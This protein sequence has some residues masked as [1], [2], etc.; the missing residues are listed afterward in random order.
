[1]PGRN[2]AVLAAVRCNRAASAGVEVGMPLAEAVSRLHDPYVVPLD[3]ER[4]RE[5]LTV[6]AADCLRYTPCVGLDDDDRPDGLLLDVTGCGHLFGGEG[7]LARRAVLDLRRGGLA[8]RGGVAGT[9]GLA[10]AAARFGDPSEPATTVSDGDRDRWLAGRPLDALR[11]DDGTV[12]KLNEFGIDTVGAL[13]GLPRRSLPSRFG[14][15]LTRRLDQ[16]CGSVPEAIRPVYP[17]EP[18]RAVRRFD[19]PV[20]GGLPD[21]LVVTLTDALITAV[22]TAFGALAIGW[23]IEAGDGEGDDAVFDVRFASP[24]REV[25]KIAALTRLR[26]ERSKLPGRYE[27]V[28]AEVLKAETIVGRQSD[29]F[30]DRTADRRRE[31]D[32]LIERLTSRLGRDRVLRP[33]LTGDPVPERS[34]TFSPAIDPTRDRSSGSPGQV[35]TPTTRPIVLLDEPQPVGVL[36]VVPD[37]PPHTLR[38][39]GREVSVR[40]GWGPER[41][42]SGWWAG[43]EV[44]RDYWTLETDRAERFWVYHDRRDG[45]WFLHGLFG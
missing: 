12:R 10:W 27:A 41:I 31:A 2:G 20:E 18:I 1:E 34:V 22:P 33:G 14:E 38:R 37:G 45:G 44:R 4:D 16:A 24:T 43:R 19:V 13:R 40:R 8:V 21:V 17:P 15:A 23:R 28:I 11:I 7:S 36:S 35:I 39:R 25:A 30:G 5:A 9:V 6:L 3:I 29:L 42:E 32:E 26:L